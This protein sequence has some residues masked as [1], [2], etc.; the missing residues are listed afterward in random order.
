MRIN[1]YQ[2]VKGKLL[3]KSAPLSWQ[4]KNP[5]ET[6]ETW[7]DVQYAEPE[8]LRQFLA[9]LDLHPLVLDRCLAHTNAPGV[10]S[11]DKTILLEF[12]AVSN[13]ETDQATYLTLFMRASVLVTIRHGSMPTLD[14]L[15]RDL[16]SNQAPSVYH[17]PQLVYLII[18]QLADLNVQRE[19]YVRDQI[20]R[21]AKKLAE[22]PSA[23]RADDL[24]RLRS[25]VDS[26]IS[27]IENHLY[28]VAGLSASD[29][30]ALRE[31]H[32]K[33]YIQDLVSE[34]EIAQRGIYRLE[35]RVNDLY[36]VYQ[37]A[38]NDRVEKRLRFLTIVSVITLPL[39]LIA[40]LLGMNVGGVPGTTEPF[41]FLIVLGVMI[42]L[43]VIEFWYFNWKGWFN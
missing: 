8:E 43:T 14:D 25:D 29:N 27:L 37:T 23:V 4:N 7:S 31:P 13:R 33:A 26:L 15:V 32:R 41:G 38:S 36:A 16:V 5:S 20:Q 18:D 11:D 17:I 34:A 6:I 21:M 9:P 30:E 1:H 3:E 19:V 2:L 39:G 22:D 24:S 10:L 12:P 28:C 40:G 35:S 42:S